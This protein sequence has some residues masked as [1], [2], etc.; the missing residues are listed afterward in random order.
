MADARSDARPE[1]WDLPVAQAL[2]EPVLMAGMPRDYAIAMGTIA[3]M[4]G[5]ALRIWWLGLAWWAAAHALGLW[6]ARSDRRFFD[7]LRRHLAKPG[8]LDA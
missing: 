5:L 8:H 7:V 6:A 4:L 1:G 2:A 3:L